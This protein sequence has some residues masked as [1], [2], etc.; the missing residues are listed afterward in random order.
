MAWTPNGRLWADALWRDFN[1]QLEE[2]LW[3]DKPHKCDHSMLRLE[4]DGFVC[5]LCKAKPRLSPS[6]AFLWRAKLAGSSD[7]I[8]RFCTQHE[9]AYVADGG[10]PGAFSFCPTC[11][12]EAY[13]CKK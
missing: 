1:R 5:H 10:G 2:N 4:G 9:E 8:R 13:G 3:S 12:A 7:P 6:K 11:M